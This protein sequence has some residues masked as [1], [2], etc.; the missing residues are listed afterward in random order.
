MINFLV[1]EGLT[2][3]GASVLL[4]LTLGDLSAAASALALSMTSVLM[5]LYTALLDGEDEPTGA[6]KESDGSADPLRWRR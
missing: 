5:V 1:Q 6:P 3:G 2:E 4:A